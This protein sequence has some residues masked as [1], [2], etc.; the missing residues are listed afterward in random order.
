[1]VKKSE[2]PDLLIAEKTNPGTTQPRRRSSTKASPKDAS[3]GIDGHASAVQTG[4]SGS[5]GT[6]PQ[7]IDG[8]EDD[9]CSTLCLVGQRQSDSSSKTCRIC[10]KTITGD[11]FVVQK[12]RV[13]I[14]LVTTSAASATGCSTG[15]PAHSQPQTLS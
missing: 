10:G 6:D 12:K 1:M 11:D 3:A 9:A 15:S 14:K 4:A 2:A 8:A 7:V 5:G 13:L